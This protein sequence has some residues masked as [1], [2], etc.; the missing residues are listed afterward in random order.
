MQQRLRVGEADSVCCLLLDLRRL[1]RCSLFREAGQKLSERRTGLFSAR[2]WQKGTEEKCGVVHSHSDFLSLAHSRSVPLTSTPQVR[3]T[4]PPFLLLCLAEILP[5]ISRQLCGQERP[6]VIN[7][8]TFHH[9]STPYPTPPHTLLLTLFF[10]SHPL[11]LFRSEERT[12]A[13]KKKKLLFREQHQLQ[14]IQ[15]PEG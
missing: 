5:P 6:A 15:Y 8:I 12:R 9:P 10:L 7:M 13:K 14:M 2:E 4:L 11:R 1:K 3:D